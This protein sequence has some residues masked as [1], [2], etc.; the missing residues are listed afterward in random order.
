MILLTGFG[1]FGKIT[2]NLSGEV[3]KIMKSEIN[4]H[5]L[6]KKILPVSWKKSL[7]HYKRIMIL[8]KMAFELVILLGIHMRRNINIEKFGWNIA[9]G[10]DNEKKLK[11]GLIK[12]GRPFYLKTILDINQIYSKLENTTHISISYFA[13]SYLCNYI[14]YWALFLSNYEYPVLFIHIPQ[15]MELDACLKKIESII[16][17]ALDM[18]KNS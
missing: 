18:H 12:R 4:N 1:P 8:S 2:K 14:Y 3:V 17:I 9:F 6:K 15:N 10:K 16:E 11:C 5:H 13:G 7:E